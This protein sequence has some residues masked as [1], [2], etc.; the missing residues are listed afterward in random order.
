[1]VKITLGYGK[2]YHSPYGKIYHSP[3]KIMDEISKIKIEN[4]V[5]ENILKEV[6]T[7]PTEENAKKKL[8]EEL[9]KIGTITFTKKEIAIMPKFIQRLILVE[10]RRCRLRTK[11]TGKNSISY[12]IR[13]RCDGYN[14]SAS[15]KTIELAKQNMLEKLKTAKPVIKIGNKNIPTTFNTFANYYFENFRREKVTKKTMENDL[16]RYNKYLKPFFQ[17]KDISK[18][19]PLDCK[20]LLNTV[21]DKG[22][23]CDELHSLLNL[24][25]KCAINH[26]IITINPL[27]MVLHIKHEKE[28]GKAL[29]KDEEKLLLNSIKNNDTKSLIALLLYTGIRPNELET[30]RKEKQFIITINSKRKNGKIEY[31]KIPICNKLKPFIIEIPKERDLKIIRKEFNTILPNHRLYD[32]RTT[33]YTRCQELSVEPT[34]R[35]LFVGHS[36]GVLGNTYT[37][38]SDEYLLK[39]G[40]KLNKWK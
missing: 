28:H 10:K 34:A 22:K 31:K 8:E 32:L 36:L 14:V 40:E 17:E 9:L 6:N 16:S 18:I 25:F 35:N 27:N 21:K 23:T 1:M 26:N 30:A 4:N 19:T 20:T 24:I 37:D 5:Y 13:F 7:F 33:F 12:E 38:I 15:G 11:K 2:N 29:T 3:I 39:E